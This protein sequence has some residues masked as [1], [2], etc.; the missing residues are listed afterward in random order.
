M[1]KLV[2]VHS[3]KLVLLLLI[4]SSISIFAQE[5]KSFSNLDEVLNFAKEKNYQFKNANYQSEI[6]S[7]AKKTAFG[8]VFS[9]RINVN[10]QSINNLNLQTSY[11]PAQVFGGNPGEFKEVFMG[12]QYVS[13]FSVQPQFDILNL[14]NIALIKS[15]KINAELTEIQNKIEE[16]SIYEQ[17]N[18]VYFNILS[19]NG[20]KKVLQENKVIAEELLRITTN[21]FK[22]GIA[23]KQEVNEAEVN[24]IAIQDKIEQVEF[25]T[26]IQYQIFNSYFE[27]T[28]N[29][30][31]TENIWDYK[32]AT[33]ITA[34]ENNL[35]TEKINFQTDLAK[36]DYK[37]LQ[38]Q[39][40]PVLSFISSF[41]WQNLSNEG[42]F[43]NNSISQNF[44]FVGL[45]LAW[46][47]P[48]VQ[49]LSSLKNKKLQLT[50]LENNKEHLQVAQL[51]TTKQLSL[52]LEKSVKQKDN[53]ETIFNLKQDTYDK[54]FNQYKEGILP[55]DKLLISQ[56]EM[57][58]SKLNLL[59]SYANIG[60]NTYKIII[61]NKF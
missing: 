55:L 14:S 18:A 56:N 22:E 51:T 30:E 19:F 6:A 59:S 5:S 8:N 49:R 25:N 31:L 29:S 39:N 58:I 34:A 54:N 48:V 60:F 24:L 44:N 15:S 57:L 28:A 7:L 16:Q 32:N 11:L 35:Q 52:D 12:L 2:N 43:D 1:Q 13:T 41:N 36:Q 42:F 20:Q 26:K 21:K 33:E 61:N 40:L 3:L 47:L 9:P 23:R 53:F 50:I 45:K 10:A 37:S 4:F 17:I 27:N 46:D 38:Y